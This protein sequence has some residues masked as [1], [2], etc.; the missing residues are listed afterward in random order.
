MAM[1]IVFR[2][3]EHAR[4]GFHAGVESPSHVVESTR[5]REKKEIPFTV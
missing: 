3:L 1:T 4:S 5:T 2:R